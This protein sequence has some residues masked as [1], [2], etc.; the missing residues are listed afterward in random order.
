MGGE[1]VLRYWLPRHSLGSP[2]R[3]RG[4]VS[5]LARMPRR[6]WIT[7]AWAGKSACTQRNGHG[8]EDHPRVGGEKQYHVV[9]WSR[10][11]GSP[12]RGRGKALPLDYTSNLHRITPAWAGKRQG[13]TV[14][15]AP[16]GDHPRVGGEKM[17]EIPGFHIIQ[18]SP[19]RG[20]GKGQDVVP[21]FGGVRITPAWAGKRAAVACPG[22]PGGDHPRVGGE[23]HTTQQATGYALGSPPRGRGKGFTCSFAS[24][25]LRITPAWAGKS[26]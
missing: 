26:R 1:K 5:A 21:R 2:P 8:F 7:P 4:K 10:C 22:W 12:P 16:I 15:L 13:P 6:M 25:K 18:G 23:K 11:L 3:G 14:G 9:V 17:D 19:P 24:V 20:R